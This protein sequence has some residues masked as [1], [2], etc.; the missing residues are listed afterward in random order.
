MKH[1]SP[2]LAML[3]TSLVIAA[4]GCSSGSSS[5][6]PAGTPSPPP[7]PPP[8]PPSPSLQVLPATYDFGKVTSTNSPAPLEVT[9]KNNGNA[10]LNVSGISFNAPADPS[11]VLNPSLGTKPCASVSPAV[12]AGDSCTVQVSFQPSANGSFTSTLRIT[13]NDA[14]SPSFGLPIQG[15]RESVT[16]LL[17]RINQLSNAC[18]GNLAT[19]YVSVTDQGGFPVLGLATPPISF[20]VTETGT[21]LP[22]LSAAYVETL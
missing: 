19:A 20:T 7:P 21:N 3:L 14:T 2:A 5:P 18:P 8:P 11:F 4:G 1:R 22:I 10:A 9:I 17:V 13:S 12:A 15:T 6:A 16:S